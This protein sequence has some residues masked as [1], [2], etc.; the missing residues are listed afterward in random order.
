MGS[1]LASLRSARKFL[2]FLRVIACI[3]F[4]FLSFASVLKMVMFENLFSLSSSHKFFYLN[5]HW[6][7]C[8][9][10][11][12]TQKLF[13]YFFYFRH[14][15][16]THT[17]RKASSHFFLRSLCFKLWKVF[18][19]CT[20]PFFNIL[21][22]DFASVFY[23]FTFQWNAYASTALISS[24]LFFNGD[25][26]SSPFNSHL[27]PTSISLQLVTNSIELF[28]DKWC[29]DILCIQLSES[30]ILLISHQLQL[31]FVECTTEQG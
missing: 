28:Q 16:L 11:C 21:C 2:A 17:R 31:S 20:L 5:F 18:Y 7:K 15:R 12:K 30:F 3:K 8:L 22:C 9:P 13:R 24:D 25:S 14:L 29:G 23:F 19:C 26:R 1:F 27:P 10:F 6:K 4:I